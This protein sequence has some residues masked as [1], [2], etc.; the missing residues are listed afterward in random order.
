MQKILKNRLM[1][2]G[3]TMQAKDMEV[4]EDLPPFLETV[5]L[6]HADELL[7]E[8]KNMRNNYGFSFNDGDTVEA[9]SNTHVPKRPIVGTPWYQPLSNPKYS[10]EFTYFGAYVQDRAE[11]IED[12]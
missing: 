12:G 6:A 8:E 4:D 11:L 10:N 3:F 5:K 7:S 1:K 9:L 2:L